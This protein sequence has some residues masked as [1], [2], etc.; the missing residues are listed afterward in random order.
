[1]VV[2]VGVPVLA[3]VEFAVFATAYF[4]AQVPILL[5]I[6]LVFRCMRVGDGNKPQVLTTHEPLRC[7]S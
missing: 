3:W 4:L 2:D 1:M 7:T 6:V 5:A